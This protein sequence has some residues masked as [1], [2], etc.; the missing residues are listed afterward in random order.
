MESNVGVSSVSSEPSSLSGLTIPEEQEQQ[1][2]P[3]PQ[4]LTSTTA[5]GKVFGS[6]AE[7]AAHYQTAWHR[8]NLKR[9]E[10][11]LPVLLESDFEARWAA[12]QA[13]HT[14]RLGK[15]KAKNKKNADNDSSI[16]TTSG[17]DH[18][19]HGKSRK[20]TNQGSSVADSSEMNEASA[21]DSSQPA[22]T[23]ASSN[24]VEIDPRQC[25]F[26]RHTAVSVESNVARMHR[27]YGFFIPD[28][29]YLTDLEGL[30]GF[31][32]EKIQLGAVCLYCH[33]IFRSPRS[34]QQHMRS[35]VH[36]KLRYEPGI[37]LEDLDVF[38]DFTEANAAFWKSK[39]ARPMLEQE[40]EGEAVT[41]SD[42]D[43]DEL[44][45][46][47]GADD[48]DDHDDEDDWEDVSDDEEGV[49]N[50]EDENGVDMDDD[51]QEMY[52]GYEEE[53]ARMG[54]NVT[55]LGE[56]VF[57][58]GRIVGHRSLRRYYK[59]RAPRKEASTAVAAAQQ[60]AGERLYR[61]R[62]YQ[63]GNG[64]STSTALVSRGGEDQ[65]KNHALVMAGIAPGTAAGRAGR[66]LLVPSTAN[67]GTYTQ[68][69]VYRYRAAMRKQRRGER[70]GQLI[71]QRT[72]TNMNRM[73]KKA[74]RLMNNVSVAHAAR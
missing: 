9:R 63:I 45:E 31:C 18:L 30:I 15:G 48:D 50:D 3:Q 34:C 71:H 22:E 46:D 1:R 39:P 17:T 25:L 20:S 67:G 23:A 42:D 8:Y 2:P 68:V 55:V 11:G 5:P 61:G 44:A 10:A 26:D 29:E 58:D 47:A 36:T 40:R 70:A 14:E 28:R 66:G 33:R 74:N 53:V 43:N 54:F 27:K 16:Q 73:D 52:R 13:V 7:L 37:D 32:H 4:Q 6:R 62:V 57:P 21:L 60:A 59:Q 12:A 51:E 49:D 41:V 35:K 69:S 56:L 24:L 38:Y 19:K 72:A 64:A 65:A